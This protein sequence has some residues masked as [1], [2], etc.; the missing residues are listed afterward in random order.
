MQLYKI[1]EMNVIGEKNLISY[2]FKFKIWN[3]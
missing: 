2:F 1:S 3:K